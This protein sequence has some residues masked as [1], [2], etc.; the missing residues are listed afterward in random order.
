MKKLLC[1]LFAC[2]ML[3]SLVSCAYH[4]RNAIWLKGNELD[5][6][7]GLNPITPISVKGKGIRGLILRETLIT[8]DNKAR[9]PKV[10]DITLT[11]EAENKG[12]FV[13]K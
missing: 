1:L 4:S 6:R 7:Y 5:G 10:P 13:V 3:I 11:E 2:F 8:F 12:G 9:L